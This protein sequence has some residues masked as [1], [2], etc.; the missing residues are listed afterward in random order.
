METKEVE[1]KTIV[2]AICPYCGTEYRR[3]CYGDTT[4]CDCFVRD[5]YKGDAEFTVVFRNPKSEVNND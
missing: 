4:T 1:A 5:R 2:L 3:E